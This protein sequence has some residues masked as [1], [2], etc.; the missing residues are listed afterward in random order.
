MADASMCGVVPVAVGRQ[1][2]ERDAS[3]STPG[4]DPVTSFGGGESS[5]PFPIRHR[6]SAEANVQQVGVRG[7]P[8]R[9]ISSL[10]AMGPGLSRFPG[11]FV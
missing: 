8:E 1:K 10:G 3:V 6:D 5:A 9:D 2:E 7:S 11:F 4:T